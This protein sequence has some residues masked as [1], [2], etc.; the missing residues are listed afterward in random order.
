[1][2]SRVAASKTTGAWSSLHHNNKLWENNLQM[3]IF[4]QDNK[5]FSFDS[6]M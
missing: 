4:H 5:L 3:P 6:E 2:E 1:L